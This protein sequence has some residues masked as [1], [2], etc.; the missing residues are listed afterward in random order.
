MEDS[1]FNRTFEPNLA[2]AIYLVDHYEKTGKLSE[3]ITKLKS[4]PNSPMQSPFPQAYIEVIQLAKNK[5]VQGLWNLFR[6]HPPGTWQMQKAMD[7]FV[8]LGDP[9]KELAMQI[10]KDQSGNTFYAAIA[11]GRMKVKEAIPKL[12]EIIRGEKNIWALGHYF[13]G[14]ALMEDVRATEVIQKYASEGTDNHKTAAERVLQSFKK[15]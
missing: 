13:L 11:L 2:S 10:L 5:D 4:Y 3:L 15:E 6:D 9:A 12:I 14:L 7:A 1:V 8:T